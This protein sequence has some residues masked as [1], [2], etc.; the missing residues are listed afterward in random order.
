MISIPF[1]LGVCTND[2]TTFIDQIYPNIESN[3]QNIDWLSE[4]AI[5]TPHNSSVNSFNEHLLESLPG[6]NIVLPSVDSTTTEDEAVLYPTEFLNSLN[7]SGLPRH[8][9]RLKIGSPI[10]LLRNLDPPKATNGTRCI[11]Q[12]VVGN[13]LEAKISDG[14]FKGEILLIP[15][16]PL[17]PTDLPFAF[18]RLQFPVR[19][20]FA[21]T[22]NKSQGQTFK[23]V[24]IDIREPCFTHG[25]LY[26]AASRT[27]SG[28]N[29]TY[30]TEDGTCM[31]YNPVYKEIF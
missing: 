14:R 30:L 17:I 4:R 26:A 20:C 11:V 12:R 5:L 2:K 15:R 10:I 16:V 18:K 3:F 21:M 9:L 22:I 25:M 28:E 31:T 13:L 8:L 19:L 1:E 7:P 24:G 29:L 23:V 27:G 6:E